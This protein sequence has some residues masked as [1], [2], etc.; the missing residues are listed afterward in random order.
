MLWYFKVFILGDQT[1]KKLWSFLYKRIV[2]GTNFLLL[3]MD[4]A[5]NLY[6]HI[7]FLITR[8]NNHS[9]PLCNNSKTLTLWKI[10]GSR[11][12][13]HSHINSWRTMQHTPYRT[14]KKESQTHTQTDTLLQVVVTLDC[15]LLQNGYNGT[16]LKTNSFSFSRLD[17]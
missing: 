8:T 9:T 16:D 1:Q 17:F 5:N 15:L 10:W 14:V 2:I 3:T 11:N 7:P 6:K 4:T 13:L 12:Q